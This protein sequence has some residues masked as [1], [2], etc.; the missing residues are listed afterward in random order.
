M[1]TNYGQFLVD[2]EHENQEILSIRLHPVL[3]GRV[4]AAVPQEG[5]IGMESLESQ[6]KNLL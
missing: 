5:M 2:A 6:L 3:D 1:S 4:G